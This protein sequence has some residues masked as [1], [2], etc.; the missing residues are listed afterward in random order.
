MRKRLSNP[1]TLLFLVL[2]VVALVGFSIYANTLK[3]ELDDA[4]RQAAPGQFISLSQGMVHYEMRGPAS[5]ETVVLVHGLATPYFIW[6]NNVQALLSAGFRV[7]RYDHYGRGYTDRP[8]VVYDRDLYDQQLLELLSKLEITSPVHLVGESMGGAVAVTFTA[9]HPDKVARLALI[10][11]AGFPVK[12]SLAIMFAKLPILGDGLMALFGDRVILEGVKEAFV[13]PDKLTDYEDRFKVQMGYAGFL[14][15]ILSTLRHMDM[16]NLVDTYQ[17]VGRQQK[18]V[19]LLWGNKD[20][21]LPFEN[22][23]RVRA[24]IPH[25]AFHEIDGAGHNLGYEFHKIVNPLLLEFL[26]AK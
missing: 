17:L 7:L 6:D 4:A 2:L 25:L 24:A 1:N 9:R 15:A 20:Q 3:P 11:P 10:A 23:D 18:P 12:E 16:H 21:V 26:S 19:L 5:A 13:D 8:D 14:R 22:S